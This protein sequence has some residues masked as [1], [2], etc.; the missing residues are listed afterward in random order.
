[1]NTYLK[2]IVM[3]I[4]F[5][6]TS[7]KSTKSGCDAYG[8]NTTKK[9]SIKIEH[10]KIEKNWKYVSRNKNNTDNLSYYFIRHIIWIKK[11]RFKKS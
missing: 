7:C 10:Y 8:Y 11:K 5:L 4:Y 3:L 9:D 2:L 6:L 1:M